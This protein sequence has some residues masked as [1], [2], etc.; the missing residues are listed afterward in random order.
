MNHKNWFVTNIHSRTFR[1]LHFASV[2]SV[3]IVEFEIL[4]LNKIEN[5]LSNGFVIVCRSFFAQY[6]YKLLNKWRFIDALSWRERCLLSAPSD[7]EVSDTIMCDN[8]PLWKLRGLTNQW[9]AVRFK[10]N[11]RWDRIFNHSNGI[12][13]INRFIYFWCRFYAI[14]FCKELSHHAYLEMF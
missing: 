12:L 10:M 4:R 13:V 2:K 14:Y 7:A 6:F 3:F 9:H 11:R 5:R 1:H 8:Q